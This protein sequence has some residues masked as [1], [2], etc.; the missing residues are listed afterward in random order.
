MTIHMRYEYSLSSIHLMT[1]TTPMLR[2]IVILL[3]WEQQYEHLYE[4]PYLFDNTRNTY[5]KSQSDT[6]MGEEFQY[7]YDDI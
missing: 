1:F 3:F 5:T 2:V 4:Y 6:D 7:L